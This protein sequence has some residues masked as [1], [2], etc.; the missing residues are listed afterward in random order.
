MDKKFIQKIKKRLE[1]EKKDLEENLARIAKKDRVLKDDYDAKF[2]DFGSDV[3]DPTSEAA[4]V[5]EYDTRFSLE[6]NLEV[7]LRDVKQALERIKKDV[8]GLCRQ[9]GKEI[10]QKRLSAF[11]TAQTCCHG[12]CAA[13]ES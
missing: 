6:A 3:Y 4:E 12:K 8:F 7:R 13:T 11:P 1:T 10:D 9:C 2:E 5:G